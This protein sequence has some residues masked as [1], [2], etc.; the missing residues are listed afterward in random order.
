[1]SDP[2]PA[3]RARPST[4]TDFTDPE[5]ALIKL[6]DT[7]V[8]QVRHLVAGRQAQGLQKTSSGHEVTIINDPYMCCVFTG[9]FNDEFLLKAKVRESF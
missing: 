8:Q 7:T 1:M 5:D 9:L 3:K 6:D 4:T 2:P